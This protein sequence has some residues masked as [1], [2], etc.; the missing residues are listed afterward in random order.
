MPRNER[1]GEEF[2][3]TLHDE[4]VG[5]DYFRTRSFA[6]SATVETV[7]VTKREMGLARLRS[8]GDDFLSR[9]EWR[10]ARRSGVGAS[11]SAALFGCGYA[12]QSIVTVYESKIV[13][14]IEE[15][16]QV[17]EKRLRIGKRMEPALR[18]IFE[19]E[20]DMPV[21]D[22]GEFTIFRHPK[23]P[24]MTATL[25]GLCWNPEIDE[26]CVVELKNVNQFAKAEWTGED[27]PLKYM[28]QVQ[29]QLAVTGLEYGYLLGLIGGQ[30]PIVKEIKRD[31]NF[32]ENVL[33]PTIREFWMHVEH[34]II[35]TVDCSEATKRA[36]A[37]MFAT[38]VD[39]ELLL[40]EECEAWDS[41]LTE[42]K[43]QLKTLKDQET[44]LENRFRAI[45]GECTVGILPRGGKYTWKTQNRKGY[46]VDPSTTRV[47]RRCK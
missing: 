22:P 9:E 15:F 40:P 29:H 33:I 19:D 6:M 37:R 16:D 12:D 18:Q 34:R 26:W 31:D 7:E 32:I 8:L 25:D 23:H 11:D 41:E 21:V 24:Y 17:T 20:T 28:V 4:W 44:L 10:L 39:D 2:G 46:W 3:V 47:L 42:V 14:A 35:P 38:T 45:L 27:P 1:W 13:E 43:E 5:G 30:D 36:L